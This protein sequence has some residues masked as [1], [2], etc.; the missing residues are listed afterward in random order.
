MTGNQLS[1]ILSERLPYLPSKYPAAQ[2]VGGHVDMLVVDCILHYN[3]LYFDNIR[4]SAR[5]LQTMNGVKRLKV[6]KFLIWVEYRSCNQFHNIM[7]PLNVKPSFAFT[8]SETMGN[9]YL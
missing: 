7:R 2:F 9:H 5:K 4:A 1:N 8:T 3:S 6:F